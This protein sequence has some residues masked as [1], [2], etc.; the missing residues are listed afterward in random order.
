MHYLWSSCCIAAKFD[1][2]WCLISA[3]SRSYC[4]QSA[5]RYEANVCMLQFAKLTNT[6]GS[7]Q[8][9]IVWLFCSSYFTNSAF[10]PILAGRRS[11]AMTV[12]VRLSV[13]VCPQFL[14][15]LPMADGSVVLWRR[16]DTLCASGFVDGVMFV[17]NA[18]RPRN[19]DWIRSSMD[20]SPWH[21][22]QTD[23]PAGSTDRDGV[24]NLRLPCLYT[25]ASLIDLL[26]I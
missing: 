14:C 19:S 24:W 7:R 18:S 17:Y 6:V 23:P 2:L 10:L 15:M 1:G 11:I 5:A 22:I 12:S 3:K 20:L 16:C 8:S 13:C 4:R 25:L 9:G 21:I 26:S